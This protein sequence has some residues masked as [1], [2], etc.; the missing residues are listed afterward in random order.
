M[1]PAPLLPAAPARVAEAGCG[2]G[3]LAAVLAAAGYD[4]AGVDRH[5]GMAESARRR[6]VRVIQADINDVVGEYDVVLFTR[7]L[8]HAENLHDTLAHAATMPAPD[9]QIVIKEFAWER[10]DDAA[11][12]FVYG[13]RAELVAAGLLD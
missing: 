4:V 10:V 12:A 2:D 6:G 13:H 11:A 3:A 1:S 7:S 8:H 9:G 5:A